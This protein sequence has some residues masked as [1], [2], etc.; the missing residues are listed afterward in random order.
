[1]SALLSFKFELV[2]NGRRF[3]RWT[4]V[5]RKLRAAAAAVALKYR[6]FAPYA[7]MALVVPGGTLMAPLLW[8]YR[9]QKKAPV[10]G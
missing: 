5:L 3:G 8:F 6:N 10:L 4:L 7:V 9:R 1:M 2:Q